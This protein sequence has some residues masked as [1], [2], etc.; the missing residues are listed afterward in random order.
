MRS[1][2]GFAYAKACG[3]IGKSFL[4]KRTR[5]LAGLHSLNDLDKIVFPNQH[6]DLQDK[7]LLADF[8]N[9][10]EK[11]TL[12]KILPV[13]NSYV[14]AVKLLVLTFK[15]YEYSELLD[16]TELDR[17]YYLELMESLFELGDED[18]ETAQKLIADEICIRNCLWMLRLRAYYNMTGAQVKKYLLDLRFMGDV[19]Q[20]KQSLAHKAKASLDFHLDMRQ[21]WEGWKWEKFLNPQEDS[22]H[23]VADPR[24]FQN[25]ASIYLRNLTYRSFHSNPLT[26]S[27]IYCFIK[28]MQY[29]E[30]LLISAA[31]GLALGMEN[32]SLFKTQEAI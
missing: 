25:A 8:K 28:L 32:P 6:K 26:L 2:N 9:R 23:W 14:P 19:F 1:D 21:H 15:G 31:E 29:E 20:K 16:G 12:D 17:R 11:R 18:R 3:I 10:I 7:E 13:I 5:L 22:K 24:Y 4:G 27:S 30:D